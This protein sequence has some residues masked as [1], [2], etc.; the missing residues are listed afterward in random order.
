[1]IH[2]D[3]KTL[4]ILRLINRR[5]DKGASWG[6]IMK[7]YSTDANIFLLESL[8]IEHYTVTKNESGEWIRFDE[9]LG[10]HRDAGFVSFSTP[11]GRE[12][13]E[14]MT[15][16]FWKWVIPT[17]ISVIALAISCLGLLCK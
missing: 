6:L 1:M 5:G 16:D 10:P 11:K 3:R 9:K 15:F 7:R 4:G 8:S 2:F 14:R 13:L 12:L 17:L